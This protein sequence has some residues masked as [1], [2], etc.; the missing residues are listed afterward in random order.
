M[1]L[2]LPS[3]NAV[4][5]TYLD[6]TADRIPD[7]QLGEGEPYWVLAQV[8]TTGTWSVFQPMAYVARQ[9]FPTTADQ[10]FIERHGSSRKIPRKAAGPASGPVLIVG[11]SAGAAQP[12][13]TLTDPSGSTFTMQA[14]VTLALAAWPTKQ[15]AGFDPTRPD[16]FI[17]D[18]PTGLAV[19]DV[20]ALGGALYVVRDLPGGSAVIVYG[21]VLAANPVGLPLTPYPGA[22]A[23]VV[24]DVAGVAGNQVPRT[25]LVLSAPAAGIATDAYALRVSGGADIESLA[26]WAA[27]MEDVDAEYPAGGNRSQIRGW[28]LGLSTKEERDAGA[29]KDYA[30]GVERSFGYPLFRGLGTADWI[31]QGARGARHLSSTKIAAEQNYIAPATPTSMNPGQV[32]MGGADLLI[33]DFTDQPQDVI[34]TIFGGPDYPPDW[35]GGPFTVDVG[36]TTTRVNTT[37]SPIGVI[38]SGGRVTVLVDNLPT[39]AYVS[40]V[41][42][43]GFNL[44]TTLTA[45]PPAGTEVVPGSALV[46]PVRDAILDMMDLLGPGDT[47]PPTRFPAPDT[48]NPCELSIPLIDK[49]VMSV[50]G[51]RTLVVT[52]PASIVVPAAKVQIQLQDLR[53]YHVP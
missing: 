22:I 53:I 37:T 48:V 35:A 30:L 17:V 8:L 5:Q 31:I 32:A 51:V 46:E 10:E 45:A 13:V 19:G 27:R 29:V 47:I 4:L 50:F 44:K 23:T 40:S 16:R 24:A 2:L 18:D 52:S 6:E 43:A 20:F 49:T 26:A 28:T 1:G 33:S 34:L 12:A 21:P 15:V 11:P 7:A 9:I 39:T 41:D 38:P 3:R 36:T 14:G 25:A 42:A